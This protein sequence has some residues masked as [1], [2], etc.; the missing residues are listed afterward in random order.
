[1]RRHFIVPDTQIRAGVDTRHIDW[2]AKAIVEY[3]PD[4]IVVIGDWFD[5]P[6][7]STHDQKGSIEAEGRRLRSDMD[8]GNAAF[9]RLWFPIEAEMERRRRGNRKRWTPERHFLFGN[10]E[11]RLSRY[12]DRN[13]ELEGMFSFD[14]LRTPGFTRHKYLKIVNIDGIKYCHYFPMPHTGKAIGGTIVSRLNNIGASFVQ[15]HQ[16]GFLYASKMY[17]DHVK[18][19]L[20]C[21][22]YYSHHEGY[23]PDDVQEAEWN[24]CVVLNE[25]HNQNGNGGTYD[26]MPLSYSYLERKYA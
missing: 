15:G 19:G 23:R 2:A 8:A 11:V 22:R 6:S 24:G 18:H 17:C 25:V 12:I 21:G 26:L 5:L 9:E 20:V 13:S 7:M 4:V 16:Q 1:M 3:L 14:D 10:H